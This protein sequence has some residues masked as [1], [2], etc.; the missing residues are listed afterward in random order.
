[1]RRFALDCWLRYSSLVVFA[2]RWLVATKTN[3]Q[4]ALLIECAGCLDH[5]ADYSGHCSAH[6]F[7]FQTF[8]QLLTEAAA[9]RQQL[10]V[11]SCRRSS[12]IAFCWGVG[13]ENGVSVRLFSP[14]VSS[15]YWTPSFCISPTKFGMPATTPIDPDPKFGFA[16]RPVLSAQP[17]NTIA[18]G[19]SLVLTQ[20]SRRYPCS[21]TLRPSKQPLL[22]H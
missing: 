14:A 9:L 3:S 10:A 12:S 1:M 17:I 21:W 16:T 7:R 2:H 4:P 19:R 20:L 11:L 15:T 6:L 13:S 18:F 8:R 22:R 5:T